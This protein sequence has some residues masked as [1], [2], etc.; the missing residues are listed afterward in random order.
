MKL[1][2]PIDS[3][4][5]LRQSIEVV[6]CPT[7]CPPTVGFISACNIAINDCVVAD[8]FNIAENKVC[9]GFDCNL[10][11]VGSCIERRLT[12]SEDRAVDNGQR[13]LSEVEIAVSDLDMIV[14][15]RPDFRTYCN[16]T[17]RACRHVGRD[18]KSA[19]CSAGHRRRADGVSPIKTA[20]RS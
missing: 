4:A 9:T 11:N 13:I 3:G 15:I 8:F 6:A 14:F 1:Q 18:N 7:A 5:V 10:G 2:D 12:V 19:R 16:S 17:S 20:L